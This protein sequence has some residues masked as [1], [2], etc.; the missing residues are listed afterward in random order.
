MA[1]ATM[2][3]LQNI[4]A[5]RMISRRYALDWLPRFPDLTASDFFLWGY[6]KERV[7]INNPQTIPQLQ[8]NFRAEIRAQQP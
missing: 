4:S 2:Q 5:K 8:E 1:N 7:F 3:V 6:R